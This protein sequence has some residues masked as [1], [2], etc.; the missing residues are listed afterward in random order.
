MFD[1]QAERDKAAQR[2]HERL[3]IPCRRHRPKNTAVDTRA[4]DL[5]HMQ[6][7]GQLDGSNDYAERWGD[8]PKLV[9][10]WA[11]NTPQTGDIY[12]FKG[13]GVYRITDVEP[14][15]GV[16]VAANAVRLLAASAAKY[17]APLQ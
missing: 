15:D 3:A 14:R 5:N 9:F 2:L 17:S 8:Q 1:L 10:L 4:R 12:A 11:E 6:P 16:R 7:I 13:G